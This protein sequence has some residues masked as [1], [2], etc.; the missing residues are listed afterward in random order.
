MIFEHVGHRRA[1]DLEPP[2]PAF[3]LTI[4]APRLCPVLI[5]EEATLRA[6]VPQVMAVA[7]RERVGVA[8]RACRRDARAS[9]PRIERG[10][11][12]LDRGLVSHSAFATRRSSRCEGTAWYE[13]RQRLCERGRAAWSARQTQAAAPPSVAK[14]PALASKRPHPAP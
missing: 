9:P 6:L 4:P 13:R 14:S 8:V 5:A 1:E 3:S 7:T 11:R 10:V 2:S 12:P